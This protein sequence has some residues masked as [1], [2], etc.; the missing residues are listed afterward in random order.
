MK[1]ANKY[2]LP[3]LLC[4][5]VLAA[6]MLGY[7]YWAKVS[8]MAT[9]PKYEEIQ[10]KTG[11]RFLADQGNVLLPAGTEMVGTYKTRIVDG[12]EKVVFVVDEIRIHLTARDENHD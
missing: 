1:T 6:L 4:S 9:K 8:Y 7:G 12:K 11:Q 3:V 2:A 5:L 10:E